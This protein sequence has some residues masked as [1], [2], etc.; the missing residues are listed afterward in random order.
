MRIP[1]ESMNQLPLTPELCESLRMLSLKKRQGVLEILSAE[2]EYEVTLLEGQIVHVDRFDHSFL[3]YLIKCLPSEERSLVSSSELERLSR[4]EAID[5]VAENTSIPR[6]KLLFLKKQYDRECLL[7]LGREKSCSFD[8]R[9]RIVR[10]EAD[11]SLDLSPGHYLLDLLEARE[12]A[13][14][15]G[16]SPAP[17]PQTTV[18]PEVESSKPR[19]VVKRVRKKS[20][21]AKVGRW[22]KTKRKKQG[23]GAF[24]LPSAEKILQGL[25]MLWFLTLVIVTPAFFANWLRQL[26][27]FAGLGD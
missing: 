4:G 13:L 16:V 9:T 27:V 20:R 26:T 22:S 23:R 2:R 14:V 5:V 7:L 19:A 18:M 15:A 17:A 24:H 25:K 8:F 10:C 11:L 6:A 1:G 3:D 12:A 21:P